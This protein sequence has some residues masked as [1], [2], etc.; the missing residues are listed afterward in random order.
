MKIDNN[1]VVSLHYTL[2]N[3]QG[4]ELDSSAGKEP[5]QYLHGGAGIIPGLEQELVGREVGDKFVVVIRPEDGYG[6]SRSELVGVVPRGQFPDG[7]EVQPGM[8]FQTQG[9][10]GES[11]LVTVTSVDGD[12]V[13]I[14]AN[15]PLAGQVLHFDVSVEHIRDATEGEV[16]HGHPH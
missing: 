10:D 5:L 9:P 2:T 4:E 8:Q 7:Q 12:S 6:E 11:Q 15:H 3:D 1:C 16:A 13:T 14:D